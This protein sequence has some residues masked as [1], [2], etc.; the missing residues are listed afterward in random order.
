M[1]ILLVATLVFLLCAGCVGTDG[2]HAGAAPRIAPAATFALHT[3]VGNATEPSIAV[4][5]D[6]T[7]Y[8]VAPAVGG[9]PHGTS[10]HLWRS[11]DGGVTFALVGTV[12]EAAGT[13][14]A[15]LAIAPDGALWIATMQ[16]TNP[17]NP[18]KT[19]G[20]NF[21]CTSVSVSHDQG[22]TFQD[23]NFAC[24]APLVP[25]DA[26]WDRPWIAHDATQ[27]YVLNWRYEGGEFLET[28]VRS[29]DNQQWVG[30]PLTTGPPMF[31]GPVTADGSTLLVPYFDSSSVLGL[32]PIGVA[33]SMDG[34]TTW[35]RHDLGRGLI[36]NFPVAAASGGQGVAAWT[37]PQSGS[38]RDS[39]QGVF[40]AKEASSAWA[41][42]PVNLDQNGTNAFA[43][44]A[45]DGGHRAVAWLHANSAEHPS[46]V[47]P[48]TP[49]SLKIWLDGQTYTVDPL[50]HRGPICVVLYGVACPEGSRGMGDFLS[51]AILKNGRVAV[52]YAADASGAT[53][54]WGL[55]KVAIGPN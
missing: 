7:I 46:K 37:A 50:V 35:T 30:G 52:A 23:N 4:A 41:T 18:E 40:A 32:P 20:P 6:G 5:P 39:A 44:A 47:A 16:Y 21:Q 38:N 11:G 51:A 1:R 54:D 55:P 12:S 3:L 13:G 33:A 22:K 27:G 48:E 49:W 15:S 29:P 53:K 17:S 34:G 31:N 9:A 10:N 45:A 2:S 14:D 43:W 36:S 25:V 19:V 42:T 28:L 24:V 26:A 8:V